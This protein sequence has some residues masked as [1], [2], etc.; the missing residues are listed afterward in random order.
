MSSESKMRAT[1]EFKA[2]PVP[3]RS[4]IIG[5]SIAG[6]VI[7]LPAVLAD[8][9]SHPLRL[10]SL[11]VL[12]AGTANVKVRLYRNTSISLLTSVVLLA[13]LA[14]GANEALLVAICGVTTQLPWHKLALHR[15]AFN[16]GMI[17]ITVRASSWTYSWCVAH[18]ESQLP[19]LLAGVLGAASV[20]YLSNS[21]GVSVIVALSKGSSILRIWYNH[22]IHT[23]PSFLT[24]GLLSILAFELLQRPGGAVLLVVT[25]VVCI[26]CYS[27]LRLCRQWLP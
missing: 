3:A 6:I 24:A 25:P 12:A 4:A 11:M 22:F 8:P 17:A 19:G 10:L 5:F 21:L 2:L 18:A 13:L 7:A 1:T 14:G 9:F 20:Y 23:A 26:G 15:V 27:S 16:T